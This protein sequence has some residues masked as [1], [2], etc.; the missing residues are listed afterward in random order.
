MEAVLDG[1]TYEETRRRAE[2][3][4]DWLL[5]E[6]V[7]P[8]LTAVLLDRFTHRLVEAG[9]PLS[10][11]TLHIPQLHPQFVARSFI[12]STGEKTE[13]LGFEHSAQNS[14][15]YT[16]SPIKHIFEGGQS[17][18]RR[19][20][21]PK[22]PIDYPVLKDLKDISVTD[23]LVS[24]L[25][26]SE[27][28]IN[29]MSIATQQPGGF[30]DNDLGV[31]NMALPAFAAVLELRQQR[32]TAQLLLDTY[33]GHKSGERVLSGAIRRGDGE[34]I[35][36]VIWYCD[37]RNF[38]ELSETQPLDAVIEAL[39]DFFEQVCKS[40]EA[41]GGEVL[42]FVGDA[43]LA[44]FQCQ[45]SE[46]NLCDA[47]DAALTA[48]DQA[49]ASIEDLSKRRQANGKPPLR[50]GIA[51]HV[52]EVMYGNVGSADRLDFTVIGPSVNLVTRLETLCAEK[53][54]TLIAS[55]ALAKASAREFNS[56]GHHNLKGI[57]EAQEAFVPAAS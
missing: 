34:A 5:Q 10:R 25:L 48:A 40:I 41:Q 23:Y 52:G 16:A 39:N 1:G 2:P 49:L 44:I 3:I 24:P 30:S 56:I 35:H 28:R 6:R 15:S 20:E 29:A 36:A 17:I 4:I 51:L 13:E 50:F 43:V 54:V 53:G 31:I 37:L 14:E 33:V 22:C 57:A 46:D 12:W 19:L 38:T 55:A 18:R 9:V 27:R 47:C 21:H 42:K 45:P 11:V 7:E 26:F 32:R 8:A